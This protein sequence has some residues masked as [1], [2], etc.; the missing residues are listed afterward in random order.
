MRTHF[1]QANLEATMADQ[2]VRATVTVR[3]DVYVG[4]RHAQVQDT[5]TVDLTDLVRL[6][7]EPIAR[8][9]MPMRLEQAA[10]AIARS[11]LERTGLGG[12]DG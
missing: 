1:R 3:L 4:D 10:G 12:S 9:M 6:R 5:E 11:M 7:K 8:H 2:S